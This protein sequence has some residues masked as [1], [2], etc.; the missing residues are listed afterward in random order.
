MLI[1]PG[2]GGILLVFGTPV[3]AAAGAV[4]MALAT[5]AFTQVRSDAGTWSS[6]R[7]TATARPRPGIM[8]GVRVLRSLPTQ[9]LVMAVFGI[10]PMVRGMLTVLIVVASIEL[11][12]LGDPGVGLLNSAI[13]LGSILGS[14]GTVLL[15]GRRRLAPV[16][17]LALVFWGLPILVVGVAPTA[18]GRGGRDGRRRHLERRPRRRRLHGAPA[19]RPE[20]GPRQRLRPV[21]GI[22]RRDGRPRWDRGARARG[23]RRGRRRARRRRQPSCPW[24]SS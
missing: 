19:D 16:F 5:V 6:A 2:F 3:V 22:R 9:A 8:A 21:R 4:G 12:G 10:Q 18:A 13:G 20:P 1:G 11:L 24:P 14:V 17:L 23:G 7:A 15:V